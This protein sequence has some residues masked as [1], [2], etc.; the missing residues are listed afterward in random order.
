MD[1]RP[2]S[3]RPTASAG[4]QEKRKMKY[5]NLSRLDSCA[6]KG[7]SPYCTRVLQQTVAFFRIRFRSDGEH[8][9]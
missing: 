5:S 7:L 9:P 2:Q 8:P 1:S 6:K 4:L 3:I